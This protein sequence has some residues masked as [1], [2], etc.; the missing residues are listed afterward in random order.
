MLETSKLLTNKIPYL[1]FE[2]G[3]LEH[4]GIGDYYYCS[5]TKGLVYCY[6][7]CSLNNYDLLVARVCLSRLEHSSVVELATTATVLMERGVGPLLFDM[8]RSLN[9]HDL[10]FVPRCYTFA[11]FLVYSQEVNRCFRFRVL[12]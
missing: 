10:L 11:S 7:I 8:A 1:S 6:L 4:W 12:P 5:G 3:M 9:D 2:L